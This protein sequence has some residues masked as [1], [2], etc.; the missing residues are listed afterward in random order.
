MTIGIFGDSYALDGD[1]SWTTYL[2]E[3]LNLDTTNYSVGGSSF[4]YSYYQFKKYNHLHDMIIFIVTSSTRGS[5]FTLKNNRPEHLAFY[6]NS[7]IA[8]LQ[9]MN[10]DEDVNDRFSKPSENWDKR[11]IKTLKNEITKNV[12]YDSNVMYHTAYLDSIKHLR[13]DTHIVFAFDF[14]TLRPGSMFNISKIDYNNLGLPEDDDFRSC[15]MSH[16]QNEE[17]ANYMQKHIETDFDIHRT[18]IN[19]EKFYTASKTKEDANWI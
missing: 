10:D 18:M 4:D 1:N 13:P 19:P 14:P 15:H 8:D 2:S 9:S 12:Y 6:Q 11:L 16:Q 7:S 17:F 5:I 3:N